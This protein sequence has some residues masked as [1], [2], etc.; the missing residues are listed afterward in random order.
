MYIVGLVLTCWCT[1]RR[2]IR[3][4]QKFSRKGTSKLK[5]TVLINFSTEKDSE[6]LSTDQQC[7]NGATES[8]F[9]VISGLSHLR[10]RNH[11]QSLC[12]IT[13][14]LKNPQI[15]GDGRVMPRDHW[16]RTP[17]SLST[18]D[19]TSTRRHHQTKIFV[20][21]LFLHR[22]NSIITRKRWEKTIIANRSQSNQCWY[23]SHLAA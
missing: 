11:F 12:G 3:Q 21:G 4:T 10:G 17:V 15:V 19:A 7:E 6:K 14:A 13:K 8:S 22:Q 23:Y 16:K 20:S 1:Q 2:E 9:D 18:D 5:D